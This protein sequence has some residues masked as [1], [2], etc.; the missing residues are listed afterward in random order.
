MTSPSIYQRFGAP[1]F[2]KMIRTTFTR[3]TALSVVMLMLAVVLG[4][5]SPASAQ[6]AG[7]VAAAIPVADCNV[8]WYVTGG[9]SSGNSAGTYG[10][11]T[12]GGQFTHVGN[13]MSN[14]TALAVNPTN[15][16]EA[17]YLA[18]PIAQG[19][20][21]RLNLTTGVSTQLNTASTAMFVANR[22]AFAPD[23]TLWTS[24][25]D[26]VLWSTIPT[27]DSVGLPINHGLPAN[28]DAGKLS[29]GDIAFDGSANMWMAFGDGT[30]LTIS[31]ADLAG[32][33]PAVTLVGKLGVGNHPGLAFSADGGLY[34]SSEGSDTVLHKVDMGNGSVTVAASGG[35]NNVGDLGSCAFPKPA[36]SPNKT[37]SPAGS[38][39][40]GT[41]LSYTVA[42]ANTGTLASTG[43][44][45]TDPVPANT[46]YVPNSTTLN[47]ETVPDINGKFPYAVA[48]EIHSTDAFAGVIVAGGN[49][50]ITYKVKV[51]DPLPVNVTQVA[52][53]ATVA[54]V[55]SA[56]KATP[57]V[58]TEIKPVVPPV[59]S[60]SL[61]KSVVEE[62]LASAGQVLHYNFL[63]TNTGTVTLSNIKVSELDFS[64]SGVRPVV[65]CPP[66][67][68]TLTPQ[69]KVK[70]S[71]TYTVTQADVNAGKMTNSA[72]ATGT[73]V[74]GPAVNSAQSKV[75]ILGNSSLGMSFSKWADDSAIQSPTQVGDVI[76]YHF[77]AS[78][79]GNVTLTAVTIKDQLAGLSPLIYVWPGSAG[80]LEP[81]QTVTATARYKV[82]QTDINAGHVANTATSTANPPSGPAVTPPQGHADTILTQWPALAFSKTGDASGVHNPA[83]V[84]D[85]IRYH[86]TVVNTGNVALRE[87]EIHDAMPGLPALVYTWPGEA[88]VLEPGQTATATASYKITQTDIA[89]GG[90]TNSATVTAKLPPGTPDGVEVVPPFNSLGSKVVVTF[91]P[92]PAVTSVPPVTKASGRGE[93]SLVEDGLARTGASLL[94]LPIGIAV[95]AGGAVL[96]LVGRRK[97]RP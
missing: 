64:G 27:A 92:A 24:D 32:T 40:P 16:N 51:D 29:G 58:V 59:G 88:G 69:A 34:A 78:N 46:S 43:S 53:V 18:S 12:P 89:A 90:I 49:A 4:I 85:V 63:V 14:S 31:K 97:R 93:N 74:T 9:S 22:M 39:S 38:V 75:E 8:I 33:S 96:L 82:T 19:I 5:S 94:M 79:T 84:G 30:L 10:Y 87:I 23:G 77:T 45:L 50:T 11:V 68:L 57:A 80:K 6:A 86:F 73:P 7:P 42:A 26:G 72:R 47:S 52:N 66:G 95:L 67:A 62:S 25:A 54:G 76:A 56:P 48:N 28:I 35:V 1:S 61:V 70:C 2:R 3:V 65:M 83:M 91:S 71:A 20:L 41:V 17:Y 81:G 55:G 44:T 36:L 60:L 15:P 21:Y 13:L 37:V